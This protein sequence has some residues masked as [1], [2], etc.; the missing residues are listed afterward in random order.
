MKLINR[1]FLMASKLFSWPWDLSAITLLAVDTALNLCYL[2]M[3][4][5]A[6]F[7]TRPALLI[8]YN[9]KKMKTKICMMP[10]APAL[11]T[12]GAGS[13]LTQEQQLFKIENKIASTRQNDLK[14][15]I[16]QADSLLFDAFNRQDLQATKDAFT[17]DLEFFHD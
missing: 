8:T 10:L 3:C 9:L 1:R 17:P 5:K 11:F 4:L 13:R 14:T 16:A 12:V 2:L 6:G 15:E 7:L